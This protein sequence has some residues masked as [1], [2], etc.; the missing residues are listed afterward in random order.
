MKHDKKNDGLISKMYGAALAPEKY[1]S[2][3]NSLEEYLLDGTS[4]GQDVDKKFEAELGDHVKT[5]YAIQKKMGRQ[6]NELPWAEALVQQIPGFAL[7]FDGTEKI[8][9]INQIAQDGFESPIKTL[10]DFPATETQLDQLRHWM[11]DPTQTGTFV[12]PAYDLDPNCNGAIIIRKVKPGPGSGPLN[13]HRDHEQETC[14]LVTGVELYVDD[15]TLK[16]LGTAYE[17]TDAE[18]KIAAQLASGLQPVDIAAQRQVSANTIRSQIKSIQRK[19]QA[20][21]V[22]DIVRLVCG[23]TAGLA[24]SYQAVNKIPAKDNPDRRLRR[25]ASFTLRDGRHMA[26]MEQGSNHGKV[27]LCLHNMLYGVEWPIRAIAAAERQKIR[28]I[29][30]ERPGYGKSDLAQSAFGDELLS[31]VAHDVCELLD[32]LGIEKADIMGLAIGSIYAMRFAKLFP[33]RV[34]RLFAIGHAPIWRDEWMVQLPRRQ[35]LIARLTKSFPAMLPLATRTGIALMDAGYK[36]KFIDALHQ[37]IPAD[38]SALQQSDIREVIVEGLDLTIA[39]GGEAFRR[40]C[41]FAIHDYSEEA[42]RLAM[43]FHFIHGEKD[44]VVPLSHIEEF[45]RQAPQSTLEVVKDAGQFVLLSHWQY[46]L[47]AIS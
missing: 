39:Q 26:Y 19:M 32:H 33:N 42:R 36:N 1:D 17:L 18:G 10:A 14:F 4:T 31:T 7:I 41:T 29:T 5:A 44:K 21:G 34:E 28:I 8:L 27:V 6:K 25:E 23:F 13:R 43:P 47:K 24:S 37:N 16:L 30:P 3:M 2:F 11:Q 20:K 38:M 12:R 9:A 40:D 45:I 46:V 35:Q 22:P 15:L